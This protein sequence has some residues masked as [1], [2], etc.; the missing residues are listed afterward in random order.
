MTTVRVKFFNKNLLGACLQ[1]VYKCIA[2]VEHCQS[3]SAIQMM[4]YFSQR[5]KLH[6]MEDGWLYAL[7]CFK[8]LNVVENDECQLSNGDCTAEKKYEY[9]IFIG[10]NLPWCRL[11]T[12]PTFHGESIIWFVHILQN[13]VAVAS[14]FLGVCERTVERYISKF[15]VNGHVKPVRVGSTR[16]TN[17]FCIPNMETTVPFGRA[18]NLRST[19]TIRRSLRQRFLK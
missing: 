9:C 8:I 4:N 2:F 1:E 14:F 16:R 5:H 10:N 15:L 13:S 18:C 7:V 19:T 17:C 11:R 6:L 3:L 12:V